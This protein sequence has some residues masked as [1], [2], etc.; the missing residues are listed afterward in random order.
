MLNYDDSP[1]INIGTGEELSIKDL[2]YKISA[3]VEKHLFKNK[4]VHLVMGPWSH[5]QWEF[6]P[7][8]ESL[9]EVEYSHTTNGS[10]QIKNKRVY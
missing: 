8:G 7:K 4:N 9:G 10:T 5:G 2:A 6:D 3:I 1:H